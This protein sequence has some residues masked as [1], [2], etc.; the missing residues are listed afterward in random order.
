MK[1]TTVHREQQHHQFDQY[2]YDYHE[3][4]E[5]IVMIIDNPNGRTTSNFRYT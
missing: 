3:L 4:K 1:E 5:Q 2:D